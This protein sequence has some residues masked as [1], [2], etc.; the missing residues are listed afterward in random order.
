MAKP[1]QRLPLILLCGK[2]ALRR[3]HRVG[4]GET[5]SAISALL[6]HFTIADGQ[7]GEELAGCAYGAKPSAGP[8]TASARPQFPQR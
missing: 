6:L 5:P 8:A 3:R 1:E 7:P 2:T 4:P